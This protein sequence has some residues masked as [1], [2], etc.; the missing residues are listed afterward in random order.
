MNIKQTSL[1][2]AAAVAGALLLATPSMAQSSGSGPTYGTMNPNMTT[3]P[4]GAPG[5][6]NTPSNTTGANAATQTNGT[7]GTS[8]HMHHH[9]RATPA[10]GSVNNGAMSNGSMNN[11]SN[12]SMSGPNSTN[13]SDSSNY[14]STTTPH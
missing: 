9:H 5:T 3:A 8:N 13:G 6:D 10:S 7:N 2:G 14:P 11:N 1:C 12:G 4:A